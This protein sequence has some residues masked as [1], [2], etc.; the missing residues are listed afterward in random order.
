M[1]N[2]SRSEVRAALLADP[3]TPLTDLARRLGVDRLRFTIVASQ[4]CQYDGINYH[5]QRLDGRK[6][7]QGRAA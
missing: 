4:V 3:T 5:A 1:R 2:P 6:V 7:R